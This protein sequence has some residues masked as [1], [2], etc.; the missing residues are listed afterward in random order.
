MGFQLIDCY[1]SLYVDPPAFLDGSD[2]AM[3][4]VSSS[5][6]GATLRHMKNVDCWEMVGETG[7]RDRS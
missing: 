1:L 3:Y 5:V 4:R 7:V 2:S 6:S